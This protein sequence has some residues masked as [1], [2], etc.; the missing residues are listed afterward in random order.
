MPE[1]PIPDMADV[2]LEGVLKA[3][4]DPTRLAIVRMLA[5]GRPRPKGEVWDAFET[6]K[7]TCAH[8]FKTLREA[9]LVAYEVHGRTHDMMLRRAELDARF[10]GLIDAVTRDA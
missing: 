1:Y 9:G 5:D 2:Q 8:H 4:A 6:T 7:A 3:L 10:P